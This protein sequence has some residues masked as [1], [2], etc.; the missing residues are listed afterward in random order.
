MKKYRATINSKQIGIRILKTDAN[1]T[2][3]EPVSMLAIRMTK[4][5][6]T[7]RTPTTTLPHNPVD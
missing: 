6:F 4:N 2:K 3:I 7:F 1:I 5:S